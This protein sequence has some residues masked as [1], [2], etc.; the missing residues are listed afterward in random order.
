M[1]GCIVVFDG[2]VRDHEH[3]DRKPPVQLER[4]FSQPLVSIREIDRDSRHG[5]PDQ[6]N[7]IFETEN[8]HSRVSL[9]SRREALDEPVDSGANQEGILRSRGRGK[10]TRPLP[11]VPIMSG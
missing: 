8:H 11:M 3:N 6:S 5:I 7:I 4:Q 2:P 1:K 9:S 10:G